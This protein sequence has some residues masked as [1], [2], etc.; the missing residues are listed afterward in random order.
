V[1]DHGGEDVT[2]RVGTRED[3]DGFYVADNGPGIPEAERDA[4]FASGY[5]T[6]EEG[7]GFGLAIVSEIVAAHDWEIDIA[8]SAEGGARFDITGVE[9]A[10]TA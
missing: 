10:A 2:V 3:G 1:I 9:P 5:S 8:E 4:V 7:T 6:G